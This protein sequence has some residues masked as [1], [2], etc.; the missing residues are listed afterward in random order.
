MMKNI[1]TTILALTVTTAA[2][3]TVHSHWDGGRNTPVHKL[4]L[5]DEF[6]DKIDPGSPTALPVSTRNTCGQCHDYETIAGG[7]HFNSSRT[8]TCAGRAS[9][10]W[11]MV[12]ATTGSQIPMSLRAWQGVY[13]PGALNMTNWEWVNTF[14]RHM[15][16]GDLG[17]PADI[18]SEGGHNARWEVSGKLEINCF[19]CHTQDK[20][21]DHSEYVRLMAREN[22]AWAATG[23]LGLGD[24]GGMGLRV[25]DYWDALRGLDKD[26]KVYKVPPHITYDMSKFDHKSRTV[27][28]VDTP[29]D[30]NCLNCHSVT[31]A[32]MGHKDIDGDVHLRAGMS[33]TDCHSNDLKHDIARGYEGDTSGSMD[34]GRA[35]ASCV[36]CH[37]GSDKTKAGRFGAPT[38]K[39]VGYPLVHFEKLSCTV[40]HSGV[41]EEGKIAQVR[42]SRANRMGVYGRARWV[43]PAPFI[44]EPVFVKNDEGKIEPRRMTWP[45]YWGTRA[46]DGSVAPLKPELVQ[47]TCAAELG[48]REHVGA[49]L[50]TLA[51]NPN[52]PGTPA[53]VIDGEC[54]A[55]N[56]DNAAM[57]RGQDDSFKGVAFIYLV[58]GTNNVAVVPNYDPHESTDNMTEEQLYAR[59]DAEVDFNELLQTLD[60]S[61]LADFRFGAVV[62]G[63]KIYY[64]GGTDEA[65]ISTNAPAGVASRTLGFFKDNEFE[66]L[67]SDYLVANVKELGGS[68]CTL[69]ESMVAACLKQLTAAGQEKPVYI[70]HGKLWEIAADGALA[71]GE[72]QAAAPVSWALGHDVRPARLARG[73]KP[74]KCADCHTVG[75]EF[76][77]ADVRSTAPLLTA[78][79][80]VQSQI[81]YMGLSG[82]YNKLFGMTFTVRPVLKIFLWIAF[83]L[84]ALVAVAF[85]AAGVPAL[86]AVGGILPGTSKEQMM[87]KVD[88]LSLLGIIAA[89]V[90]LCVSGVLG[91]FFHLMTGYLLMLHIVAGGLF[92]LCLMILVWTRGG[93]RITNLAKSW[94]WMLMLALGAVVI[95]SAVAPMMTL[96]GS[97]WQEI[98]LQTH[99]YAS[100]G[101]LVVG[102]WTLLCRCKRP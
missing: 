17:E 33:C 19:A 7:W 9:E 6:G 98:L 20:L 29:R 49:I 84:L 95:F 23:A 18:Y 8:N 14:G 77:F 46:A 2:F 4:D 59:A 52:N 38:P 88:Q 70:A 66:P 25:P 24:V 16:G 94:R 39:H 92:A 69:T 62:L 21:Y 58:E 81:A 64:R 44:L 61:P 75:S 96:F 11:F 91:W 71:A 32:G 83:V 34:R 1:L 65:V 86:L 100:I 67:L 97:D 12:D 51:T 5:R 78:K 72:N 90:Y 47:E 13:K 79:N 30:K 50:A 87:S 35:T 73:A 55:A 102:A 48:V 27:L 63:D 36:G 101:F 60:A 80:M 10:P 56:A 3:G 37:N 76:F 54:F 26:D 68:E 93:E 99:R 22:F 15:P 53:L 74:I 85:V 41:T 57:P 28:E 40:C 42:T 82:S 31:Q 89:S 45:A 43:T